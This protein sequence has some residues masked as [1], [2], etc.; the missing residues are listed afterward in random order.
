VAKLRERISLS[1]RARQSFDLERFDLKK[2]NDVEVNGKYQVR[3]SNRF[4]GLKNL[5]ESL[6]ISSAWENIRDKIKTSAYENP[7]K[8]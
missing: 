7:V 2:Q 1:K 4:A 8:A 3:I 5:Y 6:D